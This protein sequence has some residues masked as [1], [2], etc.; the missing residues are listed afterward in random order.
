MPVVSDFVVIQGN[1]QHIIGDNNIEWEQPFSTGGREPGGLA[2]LTLMV[3]GLTQA[4]ADVDVQI[5][6]E[7][8][9][10]IYRYTGANP[11]HWYSQIINIGPGVLHNGLNTL[12]LEAVGV[13]GGGGGGNDFDDFA[14]RDVVCFFQQEA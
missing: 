14:V 8:V 7:S 4:E 11:A 9:G 1:P 5:N 12:R 6:G 10:T 13:A 3:K 2:I